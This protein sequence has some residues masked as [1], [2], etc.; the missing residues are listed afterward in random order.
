MLKAAAIG[1]DVLI[2]VAI[3]AYFVT[4]GFGR[5]LALDIFLALIG[6]SDRGGCNTERQ[7]AAAGAWRCHLTARSIAAVRLAKEH[8]VNESLESL[9]RWFWISSA[10][11]TLFVAFLYVV[12]QRREL[13]LRYVSAEAGFWTRLGIPAR[14]AE[15]S[16]RFEESRTFIGILWFLVVWF[17]LLALAN[18]GA[19]VYFKSN[20]LY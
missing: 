14:I 12:T 17:L 4:D 1:V 20:L 15:S 11:T 7:T 3:G 6:S 2:L 8:R 13:W 9:L 10:M 18:G 5:N 19:Y 16:R